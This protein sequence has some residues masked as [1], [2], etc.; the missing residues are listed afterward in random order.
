MKKIIYVL[1]TVLTVLAVIGCTNIN[2]PA[3]VAKRGITITGIRIAP[4]DEL[5]GANPISQAQLLKAKYGVA[6]SLTTF[7]DAE[8]KA[9]SFAGPGIDSSWSFSKFT[10][11]CFGNVIMAKPGK[12]LDKKEYTDYYGDIEFCG[13][14]EGDWNF[15]PLQ[16]GTAVFEGET[17]KEVSGNNWKVENPRDAKEYYINVTIAAD[18]TSTVS[19]VEGVLPSPIMTIKLKLPESHKNK[20]SITLDSNISWGGAKGSW[21]TDGK[22]FST[23]TLTVTPEDGFITFYMSGTYAPSGWASEQKLEGTNF[24]LSIKDTDDLWFNITNEESQEL[25]WADGKK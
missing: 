9:V 16:D 7:A 14:A 1:L 22:K 5:N 15:F 11:F 19:L 12:D 10:G 3:N 13:N 8:G 4:V 17:F 6:D 21:S 18:G 2:D 23:G 25:D 24:K 20:D